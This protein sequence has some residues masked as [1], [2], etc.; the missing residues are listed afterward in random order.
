VALYGKNRL[1]LLATHLDRELRMWIS[2]KARLLVPILIAM[3]LMAASPANATIEKK[4]T[5]SKTGIQLVWW[6]ALAK[7]KGWHHDD[8][9]SYLDAIN[10][11]VPDGFTFS[12]AVAV[13]YAKAIYKPRQPETKSLAMLIKQDKAT[14][15]DHDRT[16]EITKVNPLETAD[17]RTL[18]T[19]TY[20]PQ[21]K[22][23][24]EEVSYGE[25]GDYYLVFVIS[26]RTK[27]GFDQA[28]PA[29][30]EFINE[31]K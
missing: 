18:E 11:E 28:L 8:D 25:E 23:N 27:A 5:L 19:Y 26:S 31:Y 14:F 13:I 24:W 7:V 2:R 20:F 12:N 21:T 1:P 9:A 6:P 30:K 3:V 17:G 22:G 15:L 4:A 29:Y 10:A 16:I